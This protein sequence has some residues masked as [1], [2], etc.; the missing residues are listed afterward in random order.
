ML[1]SGVFISCKKASDEI[2]KPMVSTPTESV[3]DST[4]SIRKE[5]S[6]INIPEFKYAEANKFANE[7]V[8][9]VK[10]YNVAIDNKDSKALNELGSKINEYQHRG[11][12]LAKRVPQD[13]VV[14]FQDFLIQIEQNFK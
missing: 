14:R 5:T 1:L 4:E 3:N 10:D 13:E 2:Q 7:Y 11:V 8:T 9:F 12:E 6:E